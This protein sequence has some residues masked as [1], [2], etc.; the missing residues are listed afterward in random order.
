MLL[1]YL[2]RKI[3]ISLLVLLSFQHHEFSPQRLG[4]QDKWGTTCQA[5]SNIQWK[6]TLSSCFPKHP[7]WSAVH[8]DWPKMALKTF[9]LH[10]LFSCFMFCFHIND[11]IP[12]HTNSDLSI[13][14]LLKNSVSFPKTGYK[15]AFTPYG[16]QQLILKSLLFAFVGC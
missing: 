14:N 12:R 3:L 2:E 4:K 10:I 15:F 8:L 5:P 11:S 1:N 13:T 16:V 9:T 6:L 7:P